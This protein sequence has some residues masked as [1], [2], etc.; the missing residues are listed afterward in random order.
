M[1]NPDTSVTMRVFSLSHQAPGRT[2]LAYT[3]MPNAT[4]TKLRSYFYG[5][6][7]VLA[8]STR[9]QAIRHSG[10]DLIAA[11]IFTSGHHKSWA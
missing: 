5:R 3:L 7:L 4:E 9:L 2:A 8:N 11:N 6:L 10:L 1:S